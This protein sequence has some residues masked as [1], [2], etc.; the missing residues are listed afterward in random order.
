MLGALAAATG[1]LALAA[2]AGNGAGLRDERLG[3]GVG[4]SSAIPTGAARTAPDAPDS[5]LLANHL[6][7][8]AFTTGLS[9]FSAVF[10]D[11]V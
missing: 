1:A 4:A 8:S 5:A 2:V 6:F 7:C 11:E 9:V 3:G 10:G